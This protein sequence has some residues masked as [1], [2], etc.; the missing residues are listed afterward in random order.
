MKFYPARLFLVAA[1]LMFSGRA[2]DAAQP[3]RALIIDGQNNHDWKN[4]TPVLKWILEDSGRFTVQV[5]TAPS[6]VP[7]QPQAPKGPL[8]PEQQ[9]AHGMALTAWKR[10]ASEAEKAK[11]SKWN[12]SRL[13]FSEFDVVIGNYNGEAWPEEVRTDFVKFVSA[14]G[15]FASVHAADN[16]FPDWPEYNEMIGVGG[17]G[18]RNEQSG[19]MIR[20]RDGKVVLDHTPGAGG[21]HGPQKPF[22]LE[23]R[24]PEHPIVKGLPLTWMHPADE[25]YAT[26]RGP[27]KK[28][29]VIA[30]AFSP[31]TKENE[32]LLMAI[33]YGK[34]RVFHT[35]LGHSPKAMH[36]RGFQVTLTR[37][38]E[39]AA[40]GKVTIAAL[41]AEELPPDQA[42]VRTP[43]LSA[44][45]T[46]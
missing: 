21:S 15:G 25:L 24:A 42:A 30:T 32:P 36:G 8:T 6:A 27:A 34:G 22:L 4:T 1:I 13:K 41:K 16:S 23:T 9:T 2:L 45:I 35:A 28:L 14:G 20:W 19:P 26:L 7:R 12:E 46:Q 39:W 29:T 3:L 38:A 44:A 40:T 37:G 5:F 33:S 31:E 17:W 10:S 43:I 18:G 11:A